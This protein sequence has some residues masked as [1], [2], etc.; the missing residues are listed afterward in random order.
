LA[1]ELLKGEFAGKNTVKIEVKKV[2]DKKQLVFNGRAEGKPVS[3]EE[4]VG[5]GAGAGGGDSPML[6]A[7]GE[8][9]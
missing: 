3:M 2:G 6:P 4:P 5:A 7:A 9:S 1:E 8:P